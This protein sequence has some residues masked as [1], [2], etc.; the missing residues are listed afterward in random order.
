M[1]IN[2]R[3]EARKKQK[4]VTGVE[5][6]AFGGPEWMNQLKKTETADWVVLWVRSCDYQK[7]ADRVRRPAR[8]GALEEKYLCHE[9]MQAVSSGFIEARW[10]G[11]TSRTPRPKLISPTRSHSAVL[12]LFNSP[13]PPQLIN[14]SKNIYSSPSRGDWFGCTL[15]R[16]KSQTVRQSNYSNALSIHPHNFAFRLSISFAQPKPAPLIT[17]QPASL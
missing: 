5:C 14:L 16:H 6:L 17:Q 10:T 8:S 4:R 9:S 12:Q 15:H 1:W 3:A 2:E 13:T 7:V 11:C